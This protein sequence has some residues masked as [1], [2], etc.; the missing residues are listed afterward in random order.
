MTEVGLIGL[1]NMGYPMAENMLA[2]F[3]GLTVFNRSQTKAEILREKGAGIAKSP[4]A[5]AEAV[6]VVIL[7]LP[8][9]KEVEAV[10]LGPD[11]ILSAKKSG[12]KILD[13]STISPADSERMHALC[14]EQDVFY[15]DCPV[16]GGPAGAAKSS[17]TVMIGASEEEM[18]NQGLKPYLEVIGN[19]F[20]YIGKI[21]GG[22]AVKVINNYIAFTTQVVNGEAL[23]MAD[24][25]KIPA[26]VFYKVAVSSSGSNTILKAKMAKVLNGD[27]N[28]G[29]ALDLV[30]K[31]LELARQL[32][33]DETIPAFMLNTGI[34][35]YRDAQRKGYGKKDSC[36][37]I[38]VIREQ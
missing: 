20:H 8:G 11:G 19:T 22:S 23:R 30:V 13:T 26:E 34:Q 3:G 29:F 32:C 33:Q 14:R 17:L 25:L 12:L 21:G 28:P 35:F 38:K 36:S 27:L 18:E 10:I 31:D 7:A 37:V 6:Q 9:P 24:A 1:G 5:L 2:R 16:S 4:A 15:V